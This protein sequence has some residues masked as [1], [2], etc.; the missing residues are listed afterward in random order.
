MR[1]TVVTFIGVLALTLSM[2]LVALG[3]HSQGCTK[4]SAQGQLH[5]SATAT[6]RVCS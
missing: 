4:A 2:A 5:R 1:T 3:G 6:A